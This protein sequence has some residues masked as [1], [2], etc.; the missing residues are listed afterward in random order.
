MLCSPFVGAAVLVEPFASGAVVLAAEA[1]SALAE[2]LVP[3]TGALWAAG[4]VEGS[5]V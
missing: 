2:A 5:I 4:A 3:F 1:G